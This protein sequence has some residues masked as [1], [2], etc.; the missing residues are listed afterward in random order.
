[1]VGMTKNILSPLCNH[2][3]G[4]SELR[5]YQAIGEEEVLWST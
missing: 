1:M 3:L 2:E 5:R 4:T